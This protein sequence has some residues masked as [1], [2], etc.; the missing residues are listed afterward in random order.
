MITMS[1]KEIRPPN[2]WCEGVSKLE[3]NDDHRDGRLF[4][5]TPGLGE[6]TIR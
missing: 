3:C 5:V 2:C 1:G 4:I 6:N